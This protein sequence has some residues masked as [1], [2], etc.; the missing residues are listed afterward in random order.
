MN[1]VSL[2]TVVMI[3]GAVSGAR[4]DIVEFSGHPDGSTEMTGATFDGALEYVPLD[5]FTGL[6]SLSLT[7]TSPPEVGGYLTG[8]VFNVDS[9]DPFAMAFLMGSSNPWFIDTGPEPAPPFGDYDAGA[10]LGASWT[11]GGSPHNG[12]AVGQT[13]AFDFLVIAMD[14]MSLSAGSFVGGQGENGFVA[15]F[16]GLSDGGSDKVPVP[17]PATASLLALAAIPACRRRR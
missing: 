17:A 10:A 9:S 3:C 14:A 12:L 5:P 4:A 16:R 6:L 1:N 11:G 8:F 2:A 13:A 7:N 15:R